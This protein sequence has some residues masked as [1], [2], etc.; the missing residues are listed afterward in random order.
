MPPNYKG[1]PFLVQL[2][3]LLL[4]QLSNWRWSWRGTIIT[5]MITPLVS[6]LALGVFARDSGPDALAYILTGNVVLSLTFE[7]LNKLA[8][9]FA[10]MRFM[11]GF[12]YFAT[13]PIARAALILATLGA[14]MLLSLPSL[15]VT[16]LAGTLVLGVP[17]QWHPLLLLVIPVAAI[18]LAALGALIGASVRTPEE[19]GTLSL[20]IT[21]ALVGI[22]PVLVPPA[23]LPD[24]FQTLGLF[25]PATYAASALRQTLLG[26]VTPRLALD[27]GVLGALTL[28]L[29]WLVSRKMDWRQP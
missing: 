28:V 13:L 1:Q 12:N 14:F 22:G 20:L 18:P 5:G 29:L 4:I 15:L 24:I 17:L 26:P 16:L 8:S 19:A 11:G 10:F 27:L 3:D 21:L 25:S 6:I 7:N 2:G 9:N 23:R